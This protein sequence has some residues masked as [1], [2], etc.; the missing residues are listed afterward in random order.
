MWKLLGKLM[1]LFGL[2]AMA[3]LLGAY[4]A[5][6]IDPNVSALPALLGVSYPYLLIANLVFLLY[7]VCSF[8]EQALR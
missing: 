2:L 6:Y 3:G 7:W 4:A 8:P 5:S 1:Y